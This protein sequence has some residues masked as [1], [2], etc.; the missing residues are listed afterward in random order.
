PVLDRAFRRGPDFRC[1]DLPVLEQNQRRNAAYA[2]FG[3]GLRVLVDVDLGD[4][5]LPLHL[6]G[7]L[8]QRGSDLLAGAA[9]FRPEINQNQA[10]TFQNIFLEGRVGNFGSAHNYPLS[11]KKSEPPAHP[12]ENSL[13]VNV[14]VTYCNV[15]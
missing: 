2:V 4:L 1:G 12:R 8:I 11:G 10:G 9:P 13:V 3:R 7:N 15:K 6:S 14:R 5:E